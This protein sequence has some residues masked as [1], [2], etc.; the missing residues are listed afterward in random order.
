[1]TNKEEIAKLKQELADQKA[2]VAELEEKAKPPKP[3]TPQP[4]QRYDPTER[5]SMPPSALAAMVNAEPRG[6]M[7]GVVAD[8]R[9]PTGPSSAVPSSQSTGGSGPTNVPGSGTGWAREIPLGPSMHQRYVEAQFDAQDAKDRAE[10]IRQHAQ[11]EAMEKLSEQ[12]EKLQKLADQVAEQNKKV[13]E[14]GK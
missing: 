13:T 12:N 7:R 6:F 11:L 5:M 10:L 3:F 1:M 9:G 2:R 4:Y 8:N 14:P